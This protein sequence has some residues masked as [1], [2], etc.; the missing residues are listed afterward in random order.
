MAFE[1]CS[2]CAGV[3]TVRK[4][5]CL[6]CGETKHSPAATPSPVPANPTL[7]I[8]SNPAGP[9]APPVPSSGS[10]PR[11]APIGGRAPLL[12]GRIT[13]LGS[14]RTEVV[15]LSVSGALSKL[16]GVVS[17]LTVAAWL[18]ITVLLPWIIL[19]ILLLIF[20]PALR[21]FAP[22]LLVAG[23]G[24]GGR[25]P[26]RPEVEIPITTFTLTS[27][28]GET[29]EVVLRGELRGGSPHFGDEVDVEGR[30]RGNG[31]VEARTVTNRVTRAQ[32][33]PR[34]HPAVT[35]ARAKIIVSIAALAVSTLMLF[36]LY[37]AMT[38]R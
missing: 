19:L 20:I 33:T 25:S 7:P 11:P 4:S 9:P 36:T 23:R 17:M 31:T 18:L 5:R 1:N 28:T 14:P 34:M 22:L 29:T 26:E 13:A 21:M 15:D 6:R 30:L 10:L 38:G 12:A 27:T 32:I 37:S 8:P 24:G 3:R 2:K 16:A 35:R